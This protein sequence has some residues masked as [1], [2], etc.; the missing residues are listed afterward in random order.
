MDNQT[1]QSLVSQLF[2]AIQQDDLEK[3]KSS[4]EELE[5][6]ERE[7]NGQEELREEETEQKEQR[8]REEKER[9][10]KGEWI[11]KLRHPSSG[12]SVVHVAAF[13]GS[14]SSLLLFLGSHYA[15][16][17]SSLLSLLSSDAFNAAHYAASEGQ[18]EFPFLLS[19]LTLQFLQPAPLFL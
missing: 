17:S 13:S 1:K 8:E 12:L 3:V 5:K 7:P 9:R 18:L 15:S 14:L 11:L 6:I 16:F 10:K 4:L 19:P 2:E